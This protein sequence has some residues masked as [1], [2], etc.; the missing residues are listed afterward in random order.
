[1]RLCTYITHVNYFY[2]LAAKITWWSLATRFS[3]T[4]LLIAKAYK[5]VGSQPVLS[6]SAKPNLVSGVLVGVAEFRWSLN[7]MGNPETPRILPFDQ[8]SQNQ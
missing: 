6:R 5:H 4:T 1:V 2:A 7:T 8:S 3:L